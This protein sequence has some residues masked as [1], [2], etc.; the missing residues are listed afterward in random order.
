MTVAPAA[1]LVK[2]KEAD[3]A[4]VAQAVH[5]VVES[6]V[7]GRDPA[8]C[9]EELGPSGVDDL[10][11]P[12]L[13]DAMTTPPFLVDRRVIVVRDAGRLSAADAAQLA[14]LLAMPVDGVTVVF[15]SGGGTIPPALQRAVAASGEV[16]D[17]TVGASLRDRKSYVVTRAKASSVRLD[18]A[19]TDRLTAQ[20]GE[21]LSRVDGMLETLAAAYGE[22]ATVGVDELAPFLGA[23]GSVPEWDLTDA[24]TAGDAATSLDVLHRL[25]GPGGRAAPAVVHTLQRTYLRLLRLDGS[26]ARTKEDAAALLSVSAFPA[27][28]LLA[29]AKTL[30]AERIRQAVAWV[31]QADED[32][33][34]ATG[35]EPQ[36]V[37]EVLV[38]RLARLHRA[39]GRG[40]T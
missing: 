22:G 7:D 28:K 35:L 12:R 34:G 21:D 6:L 38:A 11:L 20:V 26:G 5:H 30:G 19:A 27:G 1:V 4:L 16:L 29:A 8:T 18:A 31:A 24:I 33:K 40:A 13:V 9:V 17:A 39:A 37:L 10:D 23:S 14:D 32:V 36:T 15:A 2:G 25:V 3:A